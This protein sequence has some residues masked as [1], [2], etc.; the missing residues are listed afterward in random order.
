M[1][2]WLILLSALFVTHLSAAPA[3]TWVDEQGQVHYS[4][5]PVPGAREIELSA[6]QGFSASPR[7]AP[8]PRST[9]G[10]S[11]EGVRPAANYRTFNVVSPTEQETL[12]NIGANLTVRVELIPGLRA[13][14]WID[15]VLDGQRANLNVRGL[16]FSVP[17]VFRGTHSAAA[18][19]VD[20]NGFEL[21]RSPA[22]SF[23]VQQ[24]SIQNPSS[25]Q[26]PR[27]RGNQ[28]AN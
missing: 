4:D 25:P 12:W 14:H 9:Q 3:W 2:K 11:N 27:A 15:L 16:E 22:V 26:A 5:R 7:A 6:A 1:C 28:S 17:N 24:T 13:G 23:I 8:T 19:I 18:V 10:S 21:Q 20:A